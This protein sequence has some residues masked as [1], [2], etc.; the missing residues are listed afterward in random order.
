MIAL[1][2]FA[3]N[4]EPETRVAEQACQSVQHRPVSGL[5]RQTMHLPFEDYHFVAL[6]EDF[7]GKVCVAKLGE[8][9][10]LQD[11]AQRPIGMRATFADARRS[12]HLRV[13]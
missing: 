4:T 5:E 10:Y 11:A 13:E 7:D 6:H 9:D 8:P 2:A 3:A 12:R 1:V